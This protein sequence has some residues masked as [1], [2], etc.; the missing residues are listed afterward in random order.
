MRA[1]AAVVA[2]LA[3]IA[4]SS[5]AFSQG[6]P[7]GAKQ[8][9][10]Q[11][12]RQP[13]AGDMPADTGTTSADEVLKEIDRQLAEKLKGICRGCSDAKQPSQAPSDTGTTTSEET[14][15]EIDRQLAEKL[16]SICR[17]C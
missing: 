11:A 7:S 14:L 1:W 15:K 8:P 6:G 10:Q 12:P 13:K 5:G 9:S 16:K 3:G 4:L 17:G 2:I